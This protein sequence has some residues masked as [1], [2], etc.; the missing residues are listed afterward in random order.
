MNGTRIGLSQSMRDV[1]RA[2]LIGSD[3]AVSLV[4][5]G[6]ENR[7]PL[8]LCGILEKLERDGLRQCDQLPKHRRISGYREIVNHLVLRRRAADAHS[9]LVVPKQSRIHMQNV[10]VGRRCKLFIR[11]LASQLEKILTLSIRHA[12]SVAAKPVPLHSYFP[13][14]IL[15]DCRHCGQARSCCHA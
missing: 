13:T 8:A 15:F 12:H 14:L 9:P 5:H 10:I 7:H 1:I 2:A 3:A 6:N 4:Q 11:Q